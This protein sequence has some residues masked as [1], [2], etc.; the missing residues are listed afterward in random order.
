MP[1]LSILIP[2]RNEPWLKPTVED[3]LRNA[4]AD[5]EVIVILDGGW[6]V[7]PL[8]QHER[9]TLVYHPKAVGQRAGT[10]EAARLSTAKYVMKLDAHCS[11]AE[12]FDVELLA[13][14][15][16]L[17]SLVTQIPTQKNLHVFD[18]VCANQGQAPC[19]W[20]QYQGPTPPKC[21]KCGGSVRKEILWKPRRGVTTHTWRFD[22]E[23]H[24]QYWG[25]YSSRE[26][27]KNTDF[28][29][30]MSCLGACF[31][32]ERERYWQLG[33]MDEAHGSWGQMGTEVGCKSWLSGG[34]MVT[35][36]RTWFAHL[37]RTQG[38]DFSFPYEI[39]GSDQEKARVYS[40][41]LWRSNGWPGQ[42]H[43]LSW[44]IEHFAPVPGW[45]KTNEQR[46]V[47][48]SEMQKDIARSEGPAVRDGE[49][50]RVQVSPGSKGVV[51]YSDCRG[52]ETILQ[53][54]RKQLQRASLLPI[55][56]VTLAPVPFFDRGKDLLRNVVLEKER[57]YL[58]MFEQILRGVEESD[59]D[60]IFFAEHDVLYDKSHFDFVPPRRD[61]FYYNLNVWKV[62]ATTGRALHYITRQTSGL[63]AA[64]PLLLEH[65]RKRVERVKRDGFSR[66]IGFE[67]GSH[68]RAERIDDF[69]AADWQS[70][71]PNVDIRH[72]KNLT[73]SRWTKEEFRSQRNCQGWTE[74]DSVPGWPGQTKGRFAEWLADVVKER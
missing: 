67:P 65:Y 57:G 56:A 9:V 66:K 21:G 70:A 51:Y 45:E 44:L 22:S 48:L 39:H 38:G 35:N 52:D 47:P 69:G 71:V 40:R 32:M 33:G 49:E 36:K 23:L 3:I 61:T 27:F 17:G 28:P 74:G 59:A 26:E 55:V 63:C 19:D 41:N 34:R 43:P 12:G 60:F 1:E 11:L 53:A 18:W 2:S 58:T 37:F 8:E 4:R 42:I 29:E 14:A 24:F 68:A 50:S 30:T 73:S 5:T 64:R 25:D 16:E 72:S 31:F 62:D 6:P 20:R 7:E 15:K 13:A 46:S 10:N 54:A